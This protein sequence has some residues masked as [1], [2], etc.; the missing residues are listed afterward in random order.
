[1][2]WHRWLDD[3]QDN[4]FEAFDASAA[5][6]LIACPSCAAYARQM[7]SMVAGLDA[8]SKLADDEMRRGIS[9]RESNE[10]L[11]A[12]GRIAGRMAATLGRV[13]AIL[14]LTCAGLFYVWQGNR[15]EQPAGGP[16][17]RTNALD[18]PEIQVG[19]MLHGK[20]AKDMMVVAR[21]TGEPDIQF[22]QLYRVPSNPVDDES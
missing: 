13:A 19:M 2:S 11:P 22:Y 9:A 17:A 15:T 21:P 12:D 3:G 14:A 4:S 10:T 6:H 16:V 8:L 18:L 5:A 7:E 1:M 20:S